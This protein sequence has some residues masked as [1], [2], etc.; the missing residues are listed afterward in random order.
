MSKYPE[1]RRELRRL[2]R[3]PGA[4]EI[5]AVKIGVSADACDICKTDAG[6]LFTVEAEVPR[7]PH[8]GCTCRPH[9][10]RCELI[11]IRADGA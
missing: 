3:G 10:C 4:D 2:F 6:T 8:A 7:L 11:A 5:D 1:F 9:G